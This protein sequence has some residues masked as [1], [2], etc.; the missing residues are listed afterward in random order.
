MPGVRLGERREVDERLCLPLE[1]RRR[2]HDHVL[3]ER[4]FRVLELVVRRLPLTRCPA[5]A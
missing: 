3:V 4:L 2:D 5:P 1:V